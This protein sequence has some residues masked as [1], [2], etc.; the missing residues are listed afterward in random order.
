MVSYQYI[1]KK[2]TIPVPI[3]CTHSRTFGET[4]NYFDIK[5]R[6]NC[7]FC[8]S[9]FFTSLPLSQDF[10]PDHSERIYSPVPLSKIL[11]LKKKDYICLH[12][13]SQCLFV[14]FIHSFLISL[15]SSPVKICIL[16]LSCCACGLLETREFLSHFSAC[17]PIHLL[18]LNMILSVA[19]KPQCLYTLTHPKVC[20]TQ[21]FMVIFLE[22]L[23]MCGFH[24]SGLLCL[25]LLC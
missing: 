13:K 21:L 4:K 6:I 12:L 20:C 16:S 23:R 5:S 3:H 9:L 25:L 18:F 7:V 10:H 19:V 11:F 14:E 15:K 24:Y 22:L 17:K 8:V 1:E 2:R